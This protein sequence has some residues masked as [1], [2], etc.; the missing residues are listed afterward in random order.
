M[1]QSLCLDFSIIENF[2]SMQTINNKR[3]YKLQQLFKMLSLSLDTGLES[4]PPL[5]SG[6]VNDALSLKSSLT[7]TT[8]SF[9]SGRTLA[10][11]ICTPAWCCCCHGNHTGGTQPISN[12]SNAVSPQLNAD[13][14]YE[15]SFITGLFWWSWMKLRQPVLGV[16][17]LKHSVGGERVWPPG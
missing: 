5:V 7:L 11:C 17:F 10:S 16:H 6:P 15:E 8:R 9:S 4:F 14:F 2:E 13:A 1:R 3:K 12:F